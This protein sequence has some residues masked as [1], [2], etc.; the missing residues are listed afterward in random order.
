MHRADFSEPGKATK[1]ASV[2][3]HDIQAIRVVMTPVS[4][5]ALSTKPDSLDH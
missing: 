4:T 1:Y 5:A 3:A 2:P